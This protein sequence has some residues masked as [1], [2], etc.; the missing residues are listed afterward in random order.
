[1]IYIIL[2]FIPFIIIAYM[3]YA[4]FKNHKKN[5]KSAKR[6]AELL[7]KMQELD[8]IHFRLQALLQ[9]VKK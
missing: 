1:M 4:I 6:K 9:V 5:I 2:G 7:A 8:E 3:I